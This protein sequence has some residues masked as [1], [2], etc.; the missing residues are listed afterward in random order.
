MISAV[1][2]TLS[3][4]VDRLCGL[5]EQDGQRRTLNA[6]ELY[7]FLIRAYIELVVFLLYDSDSERDEQF[8]SD[9]TKLQE[10]THDHP[11]RRLVLV[12]NLIGSEADLRES[13]ETTLLCSEVGRSRFLSAAV[14][15]MRRAINVLNAYVREAD[16]DADMGTYLKGI[17]VLQRRHLNALIE[18]YGQ[19]VAEQLQYRLPFF[20]SATAALLPCPESSAPTLEFLVQSFEG[21]PAQ[22]EQIED[23]VLAESIEFLCKEIARQLRVPIAGARHDLISPLGALRSSTT[24][25]EQ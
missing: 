10:W 14:P 3:E 8:Y 12:G 7:L 16:I 24:K 18:Y 4:W 17:R 1:L 11:Q 22:L 5:V 13:C 6:Y 21:I 25:Y 15:N 20:L 19:G 9:H 2:D 23:T